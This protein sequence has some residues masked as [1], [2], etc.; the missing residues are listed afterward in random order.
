MIR[1]ATRDD[2]ARIEEIVEA[3]YTPWAELIGVRPLPMDADYAALIGAGQVFVTDDDGPHGVIVLIPEDGALLVEN[4][5]VVPDRHGRGLGGALLA[6]A[7]DHARALG[8][9]RLRLYTNELMTSNI[10]RYERLGYRETGRQDIGGRY[11]VHMSKPV[12]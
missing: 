6:F 3:A 7:E 9:P 8:L 10:A 11:V 2:R 1:T 12:G 5:A 4:V